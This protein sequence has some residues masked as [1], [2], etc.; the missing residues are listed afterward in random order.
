MPSKFV[1]ELPI[2]HE[3]QEIAQRYFFGYLTIRDKAEK[4]SELLAVINLNP[5]FWITVEHSL[6]VAMFSVGAHLRSR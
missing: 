2:F 1:D 6:L 5:W 4:D 3:E